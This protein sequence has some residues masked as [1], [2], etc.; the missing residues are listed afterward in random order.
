M[1]ALFCDKQF[2]DIETEPTKELAKAFINGCARAAQF[3]DRSM[4]GYVLPDEE[5]AMKQYEYPEEFARAM[6]DF[7]GQTP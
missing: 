7:K 1:F 2:M 5:A 3:Y 6:A 4:T